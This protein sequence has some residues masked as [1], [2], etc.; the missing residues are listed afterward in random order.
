MGL[1]LAHAHATGVHA[2]HMVVEAGHPALVFGD[3]LGLEAAKAIAGNIKPHLATRGQDGLL[4]GAVAVVARLGLVG[5]MVIK[6]AL[7]MRSASS[8]LSWPARPASPRIDSASLFW[9]CVS[10]LSIS[11]NGMRLVW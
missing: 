7:S 1:D 8:F 11:S 5:Q 4:A 10:S 3:Q 2:D 6:F 9:T